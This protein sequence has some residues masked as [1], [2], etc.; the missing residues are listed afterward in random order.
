ARRDQPPPLCQQFAGGSARL[1][2]ILLIL[3]SLLIAGFAGVF[4]LWLLGLA[5]S[6]DSRRSVQ[7][8]GMLVPV[9]VLSILALTIIHF[10]SQVCWLVA[11][12][13]DVATTQAFSL[14]GAVAVVLAFLLNGMRA[15]LLPIHLRRRTWEAP[16]WLQDR[17]AEVAGSLGMA[18]PPQ[19]RVAAD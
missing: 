15:V 10:L 12:P 8:T 14:A 3:A 7:I 11:P 18:K 2:H 4:C 16:E 9:M 5:H 1:M 19:V 6:W 13:M 17:V